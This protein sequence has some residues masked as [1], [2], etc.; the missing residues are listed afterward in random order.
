M[1]FGNKINQIL[2]EKSHITTTTP[3]TTENENKNKNKNVEVTTIKKASFL[4]K[5]ITNEDEDD[6]GNCE[7]LG[8]TEKKNQMFQMIS[9][10]NNGNNNGNNNNNNNSNNKNNEEEEDSKYWEPMPSPPT[11]IELGNSGWTL[12]HTI[13]AYYPEKPSE[14]KK[15]DIKEFL[16][17][18]SK[19][20]PCNVCAKDFREIMKET[21]PTL[22]SQNDFAL[23]LCNAH[24]NVNLQLG[25]P[26]FDCNLINKRWKINNNDE[27]H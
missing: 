13:A 26:T 19:V 1:A 11:T 5:D 20:Y 4:S 23:W 21:P 16:Q 14:K 12:L 17:S 22:D 2:D 9:N 8:V 25:K 18:F 24:N 10:N 3:T 27:F 15:Q 7:L 6:C